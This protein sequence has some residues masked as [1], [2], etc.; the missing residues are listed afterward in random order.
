M[1]MPKSP[2]PV[3]KILEKID[4]SNVDLGLYF[5]AA[6][7]YNS[8]YSHWDKVRYRT[9]DELDPK[10]VWAIMKMIRMNSYRHVKLNELEIKY[11]VIE[12]FQKTIHEIDMMAPVG[13]MSRGRFSEK[14]MK[15]YSVS[16][17]MEESIASSQMEGAATTRQVAKRMLREKRRPKNESERMIANNYD[18]MLLIKNLKDEKLTSEMILRIHKEITKDTLEDSKYEGEYRNADDVVVVDKYTGDVY[19]TPMKSEKI[20]HMMDVLCAYA[21]DDS[22]FTHP[23]IKGIIIHYLIGY[24]HPFTD[25][26]GRLARSL[27]YWYLLKK[28]YWIVEYLSISKVIKENKSKYDWSYLLSETDDN[29]VTYFIKFNLDKVEEALNDFMIHVDAKRK[30]QREFQLRL[31][32]NKNLP[33]RQQMIVKDAMMS[34]E[35]ISIQEISSK[36]QVTYQTA[37]ADIMHLE[38]LGL[39]KK[40]EKRSNQILYT[41]NENENTKNKTD[42]SIQVQSDLPKSCDKVKKLTEW[43]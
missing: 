4:R 19:H 26:N 11:S 7:K 23:L 28:G 25:G 22:I 13:F 30:E 37:R 1:K 5:E 43:Q 21:N 27:F 38:Q 24:M 8:D 9:K 32:E 10:L 15:R 3:E 42:E 16:S 36:Y 20:P 17:V 40:S 35:M 2:P 29:D 18:A 39:I 14:E 31:S 12:S 34:E 6:S 33:M 41:F